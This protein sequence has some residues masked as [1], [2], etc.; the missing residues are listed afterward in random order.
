MQSLLT[1][2]WKE[3]ASFFNSLI[4]Y[5]VI[6]VFLTGIGLFFWLFGGNVLDTRMA[7]MDI[8][9]D[10]GPYMF[11]FLV[12]AIT[13]RSFSEEVKTGTIEFLSTKPI[14]DWQI[15]LGKYFASVFLVLFSLLPTLIYYITLYIMGNP[16]GNLD[17]GATWGAYIGLFFL[18]SIFAAIGLFTSS[19]SDNQIV[20]FITGVFLCFVMYVAFDYLGDLEALSAING[21]LIKV[22]IMEHYRSISR[23]VI[24]TRDMIYF[25]TTVTIFLILTKI[26]L[27]AHKQ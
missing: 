4:A 27:N 24:D 26:S 5:M 10:I 17:Q 12:P 11:L 16:V 19:L 2:F 22:G 1:L 21:V 8:L 14:T 20:S 13:M 15:I 9:F 23:G 18:G 25:L 6:S 3:V 7:Q